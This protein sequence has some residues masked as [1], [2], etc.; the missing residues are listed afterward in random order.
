MIEYEEI[1]HLVEEDRPVRAYC[2]EC[3][4]E[5]GNHVHFYKVVTGH[6]DWGHDSI[7]SVEKMDI[8]SVDCLQNVVNIYMESTANKHNTQYLEINHSVMKLDK[9]YEEE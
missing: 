2:D 6:Y 9:S 7:E 3:G 4:A 5:L 8:C 1:K